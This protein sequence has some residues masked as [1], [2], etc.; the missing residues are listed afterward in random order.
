LVYPWPAYLQPLLTILARDHRFWPKSHPHS[1]PRPGAC[2]LT[3]QLLLGDARQT[4]ARVQQAKFQAD[5]IFLDPFSPRRCP[6]LWTCR[7]FQQIAQCLAPSGRLATYS[8]SAAVRSAM[9]QA[10]FEIGTLPLPQSNPRHPHEWAQGTIAVLPGNTT[11]LTPLS[12]LEQEHL[13]TRAG[14]A[15]RDP[16]LRD[17]AATILARQHEEQVA[18]DLESTSSWRRRWGLD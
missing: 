13:Q 7:I 1:S 11:D 12:P 16:L 8:R 15:L 3:A 6:Q 17:D 5:A 18:T 14:I 2:P 4:I 10:G 9:L